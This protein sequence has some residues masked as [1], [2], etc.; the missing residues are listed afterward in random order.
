MARTLHQYKMFG[1]PN[2]G[3]KRGN[4]DRRAVLEQNKQ[5]RNRAN[6]LGHNEWCSS[7]LHIP[8]LDFYVIANRY[9]DMLSPD[10]E[11]SRKAIDKFLRSSESL[12]YRVRN[13]DRPGVIHP[14]RVVK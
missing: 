8:E 4:A 9:P 14:S 5:L 10:A 3:T 1:L 2:D 11:I 6:P 12:P 13:T 7:V